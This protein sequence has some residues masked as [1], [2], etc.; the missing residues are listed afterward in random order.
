[1]LAIRTILC[2][3]DLSEESVPA[4]RCAHGLARDY[5][6][7]VIALH[8]Y[9]PPLNGAEAVERR[10]TDDLEEVLLAEL[11]RHTAALSDVPVEHRLVEGDPAET[12]LQFADEEGCDLIVLGTHGRTGV[13]RALMGSVAEAVSRRAACPVVTVRAGLRPALADPQPSARPA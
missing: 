7:R 3:T 6:A 1:M 5:R 2:P 11:C 12:I 9:P 8:V 13:R 10:R 4:L